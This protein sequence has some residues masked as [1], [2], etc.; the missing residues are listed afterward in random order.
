MPPVP[1]IPTTDHVNRNAAS[2]CGTNFSLPRKRDLPASTE[3]D[4]PA[5]PVPSIVS[6][7]SLEEGAPRKRGK[8]AT[9]RVS[10]DLSDQDDGDD[11]SNA[12]DNFDVFD[13]YGSEARSDMWWSAYDLRKIMKREGKFVLDLKINTSPDRLP[14]A[15]S[16]K[17]S[18]NETFKKCVDAPIAL[19]KDTSLSLSWNESSPKEE[20]SPETLN[21]TRGLERYVAPI[22]SAH[23]QMVVQSLLNTQAKLSHYD[24]ETR[25]RILGERYAHMSQVATNFA[26]VMGRCDVQL[27]ATL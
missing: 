12:T 10:F 8:F 16:L 4:C 7:S 18:I 5:S 21:T 25:T 3:E 20:T 15:S 22:M 14:L 19:E 9:K 27:A 2:S 1:F 11:D 17:Q 23:R 13:K 24:P 6:E 26:I